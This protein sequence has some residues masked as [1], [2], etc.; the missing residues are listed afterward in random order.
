MNDHG[1][2]LVPRH[3]HFPALGSEKDPHNNRGFNFALSEHVMLQNITLSF[4][5]SYHLAFLNHSGRTPMIKLI[6]NRFPHCIR[7]GTPEATQKFSSTP[8]LSPQH[9]GTATSKPPYLLFPVRV[10][11]DIPPLLHHSPTCIGCGAITKRP[12]TSAAAKCQQ[13]P[14][15]CQSPHSGRWKL[16]LEWSQPA[17]ATTR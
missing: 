17:H 1:C 2:F 9:T 13:G 12:T 16:H 8:H 15:I 10:A 3:L 5:R 14:T 7:Q 6:V 4:T 11:H